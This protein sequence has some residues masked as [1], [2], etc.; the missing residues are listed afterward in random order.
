MLAA[1]R[2]LHGIDTVG[3]LRQA[4]KSLPDDMTVGDVFSEALTLEIEKIPGTEQEIV[5]VR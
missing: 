1:K 4:L 5:T 3:G 2:E